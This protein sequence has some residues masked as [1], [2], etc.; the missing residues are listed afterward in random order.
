MVKHRS[1]CSGEMPE[2]F[3]E[4]F[5]ALL[6][7]N[8]YETVTIEQ[9]CKRVGC[10]RVSFYNYYSDKAALFNEIIVEKLNGTLKSLNYS[11]RN[12]GEYLETEIE[13]WV[14]RLFE[15]IYHN[16]KFFRI[17]YKG[18]KFQ[19]VFSEIYIIMRDF[20]D[21]K[22]LEKKRISE[23]LNVERDYYLYY[24]SSAILGIINCWISTDF[25]KTPQEMAHQLKLIFQ[26][27]KEQVFYH[28]YYAE[29]RQ[30]KETLKDPRIR[31]TQKNLTNSLLK[32]IAEKPYK[33]ITIKEI[34]ELAYCNRVTFYAHYSSKDHLLSKIVEAKNKEMSDSLN[35]PFEKNLIKLDNCSSLLT[36]VKDNVD[37]YCL[38]HPEKKIGWVYKEVYKT[39]AYFYEK[40]LRSD[41]RNYSDLPFAP[42][43]YAHFIAGGMTG[44]LYVWAKEGFKKPINELAGQWEAI[45]LRRTE[46]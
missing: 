21:E 19:G 15:F 6:A 2:Y 16:S 13:F 40:K 39:L 37:Y 32:L 7:D 35:F 8:E 25:K 18:N 14:V 27:P 17:M 42:E 33:E 20:L 10:S 34:T 41:I 46:I 22:V 5:L 3:K 26:T 31:R 1:R 36:Y 45:E 12:D 4:A 38:M 30:L 28:S 43:Y 11:R 29:T 9:I 44:I 23:T 24:L